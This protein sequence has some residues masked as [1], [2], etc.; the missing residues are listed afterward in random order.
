MPKI[1]KTNSRIQWITG[2]IKAVE[3]KAENLTMAQLA[4]DPVSNIIKKFGV[5]TRHRKVMTKHPALLNRI[6][7]KVLTKKINDAVRLIAGPNPP[8]NEHEP[9]ENDDIISINSNDD[10]VPIDE[11]NDII[12]I[13]S[14]DDVPSND[15]V[16][17]NEQVS[18][19]EIPGLDGESITSSSLPSLPSRQM[20]T[21]SSGNPEEAGEIFCFEPV[22]FA[23]G[24][25]RME[26][27]EPT[28]SPDAFAFFPNNSQNMSPVQLP[29][30]NMSPAQDLIANDENDA[31]AALDYSDANIGVG[32][33]DRI[34]AEHD[35]DE[36]ERFI[37]SLLEDYA[38]R[39]RL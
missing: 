35:R 2:A 31:I 13:N 34:L 18:V 7:K 1:V 37:D 4:E 19:D 30:Q 16:E 28:P 25:S 3:E 26:P 17:I 9:V 38:S 8:N 33:E 20:S 36:A 6:G 29:A 27:M 32:I 15:D 12:S 22:F 14:D 5:K 39:N 24:P 21:P 11:E 23:P 10:N